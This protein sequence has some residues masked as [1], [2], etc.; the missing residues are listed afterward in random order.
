MSKARVPVWLVATVVCAALP[1]ILGRIGVWGFDQYHALILCFGVTYAL[2]ALPLNLL[3]GYADRSRFGDVVIGKPTI[4]V[5]GLV[6]GTWLWT[7][8]DV[9]VSLRRAPPGVE[10]ER[11]RL[12]D[13]LALD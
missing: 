12:R 2:A 13:W 8:D 6:A 10:E 1:P 7:G 9:E 3:I 5:D 4:L 11:S